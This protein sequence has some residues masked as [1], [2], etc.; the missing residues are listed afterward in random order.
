MLTRLNKN[1]ALIRSSDTASGM[2]RKRLGKDEDVE[3]ALFDWFKFT[4]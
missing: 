1:E 2:K 3:K 4:H